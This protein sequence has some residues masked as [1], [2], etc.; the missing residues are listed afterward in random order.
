MLRFIPGLIG[1]LLAGIFA[2]SARR[3]YV[4]LERH[5]LPG[6]PPVSHWH[7]IE[8]TK[9]A[10]HERAVRKRVL[11]LRRFSELAYLALIVAVMFL[12]GARD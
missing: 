12:A 7:W 9:P 5:R 4:A 6:V 1:L 8:R 11:L 2:F 3:L 10:H